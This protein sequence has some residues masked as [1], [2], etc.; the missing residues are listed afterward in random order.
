[1]TARSGGRVPACFSYDSGMPKPTTSPFLA[2]LLVL[3]SC[4]TLRAEPQSAPKS[5]TRAG[6]TGDAKSGAASGADD[7]AQ[8]DAKAADKSDEPVL[9]VTEHTLTVG[10]KTLKYHA[11]AGYMLL[12]EEEGKPLTPG[13]TPSAPSAPRRRKG[14]G[15]GDDKDAKEGLKPKA[16]VF[17]VAYTLDDVTRSGHAA[18]HVPFNGGPGSASSGCTWARWRP[19]RVEL[20][21]EGEAPPPP[22]QLVDNEI[23]LARPDR[24]GVHRPG[25]RPATAAPPPNED[26]ASSTA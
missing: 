11:T 20:T 17:F 13:S 9:S 12:K 26:P 14:E 2:L 8:S 6:A 22:Y 5:D 3:V 16:K 21:D 19:R 24:P 15:H 10:G 1:M 18:G 25:R 23:D 7:D 4:S